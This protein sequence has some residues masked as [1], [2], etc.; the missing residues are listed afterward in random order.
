MAAN[1]QGSPNPR[2]IFTELLPLMFPIA[3]S[4]YFP[5]IKAARDAKVSGM[6][7]P[8]ATRVIAR[9]KNLV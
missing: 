5:P 6:D 9:K 3:S 4:A 2:K 8:S 1:D 7:V